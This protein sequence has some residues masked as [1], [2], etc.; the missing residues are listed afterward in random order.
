MT[1]CFTEPGRGRKQCE[2]CKKYVGVRT[3]TCGCGSTFV[4]GLESKVKKTK[5]K[6]R[7]KAKSVSKPV[8]EEEE[9]VKPRWIIYAPAGKPKVTLEGHTRT[10]IK[11]WMSK[12]RK[13]ALD[14]GMVFHP[15]AYKYYIT[16]FYT[17]LTPE[18]KKCMRMIDKVCTEEEFQNAQ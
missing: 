5:V 12:T 6:T 2:G 9:W 8:V 7:K 3:K 18:Y 1:K 11:D 17:I 15:E 10:K 16:Y 14:E 4:T 13:I